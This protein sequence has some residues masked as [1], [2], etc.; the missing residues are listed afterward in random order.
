MTKNTPVGGWVDKEEV[1]RNVQMRIQERREVR[2]SKEGQTIPQQSKYEVMKLPPKVDYKLEYIP[3]KETHEFLAVKVTPGDDVDRY[4]NEQ[5]EVKPQRSM[6]AESVY[7]KEEFG[8]MDQRPRFLPN[9]QSGQQAGYFFNMPDE[10]R[11]PPTRLHLA[12]GIK[13]AD[14][15]HRDLARDWSRREPEEDRYENHPSRNWSDGRGLPNNPGA[16]RNAVSGEAEDVYH[17]RFVD[18]LD[19]RS[20]FDST[21]GSQI[22]ESVDGPRDREAERQTN[23][24]SFTSFLP[25]NRELLNPKHFNIR[26]SRGY[27][28]AELGA[29]GTNQRVFT[30]TPREREREWTMDHGPWTTVFFIFAKNKTRIRAKVSTFQR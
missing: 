12:S 13:Y 3:L 25:P 16:K 29:C 26:E 11:R 21:H 7:S 22:Y 23:Q 6:T 17:P 9:R 30:P 20:T 5:V 2:L 28:G 27:I 14:P 4:E 8:Q 19:G 18:V 10:F 1:E 24:A 15:Y